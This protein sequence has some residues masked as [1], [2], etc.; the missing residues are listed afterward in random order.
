MIGTIEV[1]IEV[2]SK[3]KVIRLVSEECYVKKYIQ[4]FT[5]TIYKKNH[6]NLQKYIFVGS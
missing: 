4:N 3:L 5:H 1:I 2:K 6:P